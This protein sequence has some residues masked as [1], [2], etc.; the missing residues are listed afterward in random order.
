VLPLK[1]EQLVN[2]RVI[3]VRW[4]TYMCSLCFFVSLRVWLTVSNQSISDY[5]ISHCHCTCLCDYGQVRR[6]NECN[7]ENTFIPS[8]DSVF[9][10]YPD[11]WSLIHLQLGCHLKHSTSELETY[12]TQHAVLF[13]SYLVYNMTHNFYPRYFYETCPRSRRL[14][15][16]SSN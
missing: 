10:I 5:V 6:C 12:R 3:L 9:W 1:C 7:L 14:N 8:L 15:F 4:R 13:S 2:Q 11:W 16:K